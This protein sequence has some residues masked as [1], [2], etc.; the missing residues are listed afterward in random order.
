MTPKTPFPCSYWVAPAMLLAG[1]YPGA[2]SIGKARRKVKALLDSGIREIVNL[3]EVD[4]RDFLGNPFT[5]Y[6]SLVRP[7]RGHCRRFPIRDMGVPTQAFMQTI[8]DHIDA[9]LAAN[10][11]V[12]VHCLA[13][14]GRTGTVVGCWLIRHGRASGANVIATIQALRRHEPHA[15]WPSP[16]SAVQID[17]VR[18]WQRGD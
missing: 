2:R 13:G 6:T 11:P 1:E 4:E 14:V 10:R 5:P 12:Y 8:L 17:M 16:Q 3:M 15:H 7:S 9:A 18:H